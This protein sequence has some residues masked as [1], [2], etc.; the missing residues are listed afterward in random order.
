MSRPSM[1]ENR[2]MADALTF[3]M[4]ES[5]FTGEHLMSREQ[6]VFAHVSTV[7]SDSRCREL[8]REIF[9]GTQA[10]ELKHKTLA[11][12]SERDREIPSA[13][14]LSRSRPASRRRRSG[15]APCAPPTKYLSTRINPDKLG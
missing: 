13:A 15:R 1:A 4:D 3:F 14:P 11:Q 5:G 8:Y 6:P 7:L 10:R 12:S 9:A 2:S